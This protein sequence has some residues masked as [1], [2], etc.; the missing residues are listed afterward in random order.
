MRPTAG[1]FSMGDNPGNFA[2]YSC[3]IYGDFKTNLKPKE[4]VICAGKESNC[5]DAATTAPNGRVYF[6]FAFRLVGT[7]ALG[8]VAYRAAR[9]ALGTHVGNWGRICVFR[10]N[11][12][13]GRKKCDAFF[14]EGGMVHAHRLVA[15]IDI[16]VSN[17]VFVNDDPWD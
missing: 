9:Q 8:S 3:R 13:A 7:F 14:R 11:C 16:P 6:G 2:G 12:F 15:S 5:D 1:N 17:F 10:L 4:W